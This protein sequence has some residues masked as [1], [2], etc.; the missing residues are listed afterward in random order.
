MLCVN[1]CYVSTFCYLL[2]FF[3]FFC[4]FW[5]F[6]DFAKCVFVFVF[7]VVYCI[8]WRYGIE[9]SYQKI[10]N[11]DLKICKEKK[12]FKLTFF[13]FFFLLFLKSLVYQPLNIDSTRRC[14]WEWCKN[15]NSNISSL[16]SVCFFDFIKMWKWDFLSHFWDS[17][18]DKK[19]QQ[20]QKVT[21]V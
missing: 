4:M 13:F 19:S 8:V 11:K 7:V 5:L 21:V 1:T 3:F 17:N 9:L 6:C 2:F 10:K 16:Y 12:K 15:N 14:E 20:I 18:C